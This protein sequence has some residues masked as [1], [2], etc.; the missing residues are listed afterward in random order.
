MHRRTSLAIIS[1][2]MFSFSSYTIPVQA[3]GAKGGQGPERVVSVYTDTVQYHE[4]SQSISLIGKLQSVQ[5]VSVA[6]EVA[7]KVDSIKIT[8]NQTVTAGQLLVQLDDSKAQAVLME[9]NAYF[10][11]E[12]RK[13]NEYATLVKSNAITQTEVFAQTALVDIAKARLAAAQANM[14][15]HYLTAPFAGTVGLLDFSRGKMV[16]VGTELLTLDDLS[17]MQLDLA[18]PERYLSQLSTGMVVTAT[19]RAWDDQRFKGE[20]VAIDSRINPETLNLRVRVNFENTDNHLK[21]GMMMSSSVVFPVINEPIIPVQAIEYS[22]TKRFVYVVG[23]DERVTRTQV[24]LG[25]RIVDQVLIENGLDIG[26]R[27]VVQGLVNMRNGLQVKDL[28]D[29][30]ETN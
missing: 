15:D 4:V 19:S 7:G 26:D 24:F 6:P 9:A 28:T 22:G 10:T 16:S 18:V 1:A 20:V 3:K 8:A 13:L 29:Q 21:P 12:Q 17:T 11:D 27:I 30:Q 25:A 5:F 2:L 14:D 23:E